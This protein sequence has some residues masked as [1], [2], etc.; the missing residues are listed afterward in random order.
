MAELD[1]L[2]GSSPAMRQTRAKAERLLQGRSERLPP[3]LLQGE[4]GTGKGLLARSLHGDSARRKRPFVEVNCSAIPE[5]LLESELFGF[6]RGAFTDA[7]KPKA[8]LFQIAH[9]GTL[10]LDEVSLLP[11]HLQPKLLKVLEDRA[12]RRLGGTQAE[13]ADVW[14][15]TASNEDLAQAVA[16]KR[17]RADLFHRLAVFSI[18]LPPLRERGDD[19]LQL[20]DAFL[21]RT[22]EDYGLGHKRLSSEARTALR[23]HAFSGNA[24]EL[25]N[26]IERAALL[27]FGEQIEARTLELT[28]STS[29]EG[30]AAP[31]VAPEPADESDLAVNDVFRRHLLAVLSATDW[32]ITRTATTLGIAR[33][34]LRAR[35]RKYG[36]TRE[37]SEPSDA[38]SEA[39]PSTAR[40]HDTKWRTQMLA[41]VQVELVREHDPADAHEV[42]RAEQKLRGFGARTEQ[43]SRT[44]LVAVLGVEPVEDSARRATLAA[45]AILHQSG[46]KA[47]KIGLRVAVHAAQAWVR[48]GEQAPID[49]GSKQAALDVLTELEASRPSQETGVLLSADAALF[50]ARDFQLRPSGTAGFIASAARP[51]KTLEGPRTCWVG[52]KVELELLL[53]R[54]QRAGT[55]QTHVVSVVGDPGIGKSRL[56]SELWQRA[57]TDVRWV[58]VRCWSHLAQ[59]PYAVAMDLI[60]QLSGIVDADDAETAKIKLC[61]AARPLTHSAAMLTALLALFGFS[62]T[63]RAE[64]LA[65][66]ARK[67]AVIAGVI[68]LASAAIREQ[69]LVLALEDVHWLDATSEECVAALVDTLASERVLVITAQRAGREFSWRRSPSFTQLALPPLTDAES[70]VV[71][72]G[73]AGAERLSAQRLRSV[74]TR[75]EGNPFF[76][77]ELT[78][79][80]LQDPDESLRLPQTISGVLLFRLRS[81]ANEW[82]QTLEVAAVLGRQF[83]RAQLERLLPDET[84]LGAALVALRRHDLLLE[85]SGP[86]PMVAFRHALTQEVAYEEIPPE[87]RRA[88]HGA[89][90]DALEQ[91]YAHRREEVID[92]IA[93]H[94]DRATDPDR[95]IEALLASAARAARGFAL[96]QALLQLGRARERTQ[97]LAERRRAEYEIDIENRRA[98]V[99]CLSGRYRDCLAELE[100]HEARVNALTRADLAGNYHFWLAYVNSLLGRQEAAVEHARRAI[101]LAEGPEA[102][103]LLGR[104]S[105]VLAREAFFDCRFAEGVELGQRAVEQLEAADDSAWLGQAYWIV[106]IN[107]LFMGDTNDCLASEQRA[108]DVGDRLGDARVSAYAR[109]TAGFAYACAGDSASAIIQC[110]QAVDTS[111]DPVGDALARGFLGFAYLRALA[112]P[113]AIEHLA[114]TVDALSRLGLH[115]QQGTF[116]AFLA[117]TWLA[118]GD[119]ER[120]QREASEALATCNEAHFPFG[121]AWAERALARVHAQRGARRE[122]LAHFERAR[123]GFERIGARLELRVTEQERAML[124]E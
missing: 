108:S 20:A 8:G 43:M 34:T 49:H 36:L 11:L 6:E 66:E 99:L 111:R 24:R 116:H 70:E 33:N 2:L 105:F 35:I 28:A 30:V 23:R 89:A 4:T 107:Q 121:A 72:S 53:D 84:G 1:R 67:Q 120:A 115:K 123:A 68:A 109:W 26:A 69:P 9:Q 80:V 51:V 42:T 60:R 58:E 88:L 114:A 38:A 124:G 57:G 29:I 92:T 76:I 56:L 96:E 82:R 37:H 73:V 90:A 18:A 100:R 101:A 40:A 87:R 78:R 81:L 75:T 112:L 50:A 54:L 12:V 13:A 10:F 48:P 64:Q 7:H 45:L 65:P 77:E 102:A 22:C 17:F 3:V 74:L 21:K 93:Y 106:G 110:R 79:S 95:A 62:E 15:I 98:S 104:A 85:T 14:L 52:R 25:A 61:A 39:A 19:V 103:A 117:D 91:N 118:Y 5:Q 16:E 97:E 122:A 119:G 94:R 86:E 41:F 83:P 32:N 31:R 55:G 44:G 113:A 71:A 47:E 27:S 63:G 59:V 46:E